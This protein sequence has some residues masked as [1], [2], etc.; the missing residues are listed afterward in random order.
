VAPQRQKQSGGTPSPEPEPLL[1]AAASG[2]PPKNPGELG[3]TAANAGQVWQQAQAKLSGV[4]LANT[5]EHQSVEAPTAHK[6]R[7]TF[8]EKY[9]ICKSICE[10]AEH[11][12]KI[13]QAVASVTG[14]LV[15]VEYV[16]AESDSGQ[17]KETL[18]RP[19]SRQE[20]MAAI[21]ENPL[22]QR[23]QKLFGA[24]PTSID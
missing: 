21:A 15:R 8:S 11:A 22:V 19:A 17:E 14:T 16:I 23:A 3:L 18:P 13:E 10:Q 20:K 2:N 5:H 1:Q 7:V 6:L 24:R 12:R 4:V 9:S